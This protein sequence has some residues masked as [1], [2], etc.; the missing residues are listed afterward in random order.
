MGSAQT[1]NSC[2]VDILWQVPNNIQDG[3]LICYAPHSK[4]IKK[5]PHLCGGLTI[6]ICNTLRM[7]IHKYDILF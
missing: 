4:R 3:D 5:P 6:I 1:G 7:H 2:T